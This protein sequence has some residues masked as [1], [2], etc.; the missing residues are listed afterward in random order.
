MRILL[1]IFTSYHRLIIEAFDYALCI[2]GKR[3]FRD[4]LTCS[5]NRRMLKRQD[6]QGIYKS[7]DLSR[8]KYIANE[9]SK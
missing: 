7:L 3:Y 5:A 6:Y 2:L 8:K 4:I 1:L 9:P